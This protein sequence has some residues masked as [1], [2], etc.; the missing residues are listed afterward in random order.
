MQ[1]TAPAESVS[2]TRVALLKP[3]PAFLD[4]LRHRSPVLLESDARALAPTNPRRIH[5]LYAAAEKFA[6]WA[7]HEVLAHWQSRKDTYALEI[8][9]YW[10]GICEWLPPTNQSTSAGQFCAAWDLWYQKGDRL[11]ASQAF[12]QLSFQHPLA[13][14]CIARLIGKVSSSACGLDTSIPYAPMQGWLRYSGPITRTVKALQCLAVSVTSLRYPDGYEH[15]HKKN[16]CCNHAVLAARVAC[17]LGCSEAATFL[18]DVCGSRTL[19]L[20]PLLCYASHQ[21]LMAS[22]AVRDLRQWCINTPRSISLVEQQQVDRFLSIAFCEF[23]DLLAQEEWQDRDV[24]VIP[25]Y[26]EFR[27]LSRE[28]RYGDAFEVRGNVQRFYIAIFH[29]FSCN[30]HDITS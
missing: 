17:I 30:A 6:P 10:R 19:E 2:G 21:S 23:R 18:I 13:A 28:R 8:A 9:E 24:C 16:A 27:L 15:G 29:P 25:Q 5:L 12:Y 3:A 26:E 22:A 14:A 7:C 1:L 11:S 20:G 4:D